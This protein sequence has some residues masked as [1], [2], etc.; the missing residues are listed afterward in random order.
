MSESLLRPAV[1]FDRD[2]VLNKDHGYVGDIDRFEWTE[3]AIA[4][5][6][7]AN[8]RGYLI[9]VVTNQSGVARGYYD[10][11]A[12]HRL[13]AHMQ[14][15]L[16][17]QGAHVDAFR[18]CP[19]HPDGTVERYARACSWRKPAPGMLLDLLAEWPVARGRSLVVGDQLSDM[20][21]AAAADI[22][23][24]L[25]DGTDLKALLERTLTGAA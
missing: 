17:A 14:R 18:F 5:V 23:S 21:A 8:D 9:F 13:H 15:E 2:G 24:V 11:D 22:A 7:F 20:K 3:T 1:F 6:K 16:Q 4:A 19:H 10:E 25:F 12:V